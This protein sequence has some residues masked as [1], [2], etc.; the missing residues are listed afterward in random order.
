MRDEKKQQIRKLLKDKLGLSNVNDLVLCDCNYN[1]GMFGCINYDESMAGGDGRMVNAT[2][3]D[4]QNM[5][6]SNMNGQQ[7]GTI[8]AALGGCG[9]RREHAGAA[10]SAGQNYLGCCAAALRDKDD[11]KMTKSQTALAAYFNKFK[12]ENLDYFNELTAI[13]F[14]DLFKFR[15]LLGSG[16]YGVV[17]IVQDMYTKPQTTDEQSLSDETTALK[18]INKQRLSSE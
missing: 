5:G 12:A 18:I 9:A 1:G 8:G 14:S 17:I 2:K 13:K 6:G 16:S 11:M 4:W 15:G 10:M 7:S 3:H